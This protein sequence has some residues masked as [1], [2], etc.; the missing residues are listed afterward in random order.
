[1]GSGGAWAGQR[2]LGKLR[3]SLARLFTLHVHT[4]TD[5][6]HIRWVVR[7]VLSSFLS[8]LPRGRS[9]LCL[10]LDSGP[11][12]RSRVAVIHSVTFPQLTG[13]RF[14]WLVASVLGEGLAFPR[15]IAAHHPP[16]SGSR[17][18]CSRVG[19]CDLPRFPSSPFLRPRP[20]SP[21]RL[22][23]CWSL[24]AC[25]RKSWRV[26]PVSG[27]SRSAGGPRQAVHITPFRS[28][29]SSR[30]ACPVLTFPIGL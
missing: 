8:W 2:G 5:T 12:A 14:R 27:Q 10:S 19:W 4:L 21:L 23:G 20:V 26:E 1:M 16:A 15:Y 11:C 25:R 18:G 7:S 22:L 3:G 6:S 17:V 28:P 30:H 29:D 13:F 9:T 24:S